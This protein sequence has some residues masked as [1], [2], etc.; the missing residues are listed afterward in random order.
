M[1]HE[2]LT[3]A[4]KEL[5]RKFVTENFRNPTSNEFLVI[6]TAMLMGVNIALESFRG[7]MTSVHVPKA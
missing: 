2:D 6:E 3:K 1:K 4:V 5:S 7:E